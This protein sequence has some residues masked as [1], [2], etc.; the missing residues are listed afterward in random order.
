MNYRIL[1][2]VPILAITHILAPEEAFRVLFL[3]AFFA[4]FL[5]FIFKI[6]KIQPTIIQY[7]IHNIKKIIHYYVIIYYIMHEV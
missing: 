3:M 6:Q 4:I 2:H 1:L 5:G 7:I